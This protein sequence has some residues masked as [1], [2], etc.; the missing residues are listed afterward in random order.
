MTKAE[1]RWCQLE[2]Y[3][4]PSSR[5]LPCGNQVW[6]SRQQKN[7]PWQS[8]P[9]RPDVAAGCR[10][11][12]K[13]ALNQLF[14]VSHVLCATQP[15]FLLSYAERLVCALASACA[16]FYSRRHQNQLSPLH[17]AS[18]EATER[19]PVLSSEHVLIDPEQALD[20]NT[21]LSLLEYVNKW[22]RSDCDAEL[23]SLKA[24]L[25]SLGSG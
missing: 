17:H 2:R 18:L 3:T 19:K 15:D 6:A 13:R 24:N 4:T 8:I 7:F 16:R 20:E 5:R 11:S 25:S 9:Q 22:N 12:C 10:G 23:V 14:W 1:G 21:G